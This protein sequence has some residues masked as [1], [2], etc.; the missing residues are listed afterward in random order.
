MGIRSLLQLIRDSCKLK[1]S[2][3]Y[4]DSK[5]V[6]LIDGNG[7]MFAMLDSLDKTERRELGGSYQAY[8]SAIVTE[9]TRLRGLGFQLIVYFDGTSKMKACTA[10]KRLDSRLESWH[11]LLDSVINGGKVDQGS[12]PLPVLLTHQFQATLEAMQISVVFC[13]SEAD[14]Q[15]AIDCQRINNH[16]KEVGERCYVYAN[17]R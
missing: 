7:W 1:H 6:L 17:D 13:P 10:K 11:T 9:V 16:Y 15:L 2:A 4:I 5:S 12:L 14:Q 8:H 3:E